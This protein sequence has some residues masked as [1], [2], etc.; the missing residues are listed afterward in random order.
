VICAKKIAPADN[1]PERF[2]KFALL[3]LANFGAEKFAVALEADFSAAEQ[4]SYRRDRFLVVG[5][6]RTDGKDQIAEREFGSWL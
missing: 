2:K 4:V 5:R 1:P 6:A 3:K